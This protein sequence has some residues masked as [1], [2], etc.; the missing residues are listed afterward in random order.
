M[1]DGLCPYHHQDPY[2][3]FLILGEVS[4]SSSSWLS[5]KPQ[6]QYLPSGPLSSSSFWALTSRV[7]WAAR[8]GLSLAICSAAP[9]YLLGAQSFP[10]WA[11]LTP[12]LAYIYIPSCEMSLP[13]FTLPQPGRRASRAHTGLPQVFLSTWFSCSYPRPVTQR[14]CNVALGWGCQ[15]PSCSL[16]LFP[17]RVSCS[18]CSVQPQS[19]SPWLPLPTLSR[20]LPAPFAGSLWLVPLG[21]SLVPLFT[22]ASK[23]LFLLTV[24]WSLSLS[25][26]PVY[27]F[28]WLSLVQLFYASHFVFPLTDPWCL[29]L[30]CVPFNSCPSS[31]SLVCGTVCLIVP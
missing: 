28:L 8:I 7:Q 5:S 9:C 22:V 20:L 29:G 27:C 13:F 26:C 18:D 14:L 3:D 2:K 6:G 21:S 4:H 11:G 19:S 16:C 12:A 15:D 31:W 30:S 25:W 23:F 17:I 10:F 1:E 24:P